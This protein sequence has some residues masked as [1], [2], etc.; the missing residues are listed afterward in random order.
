[1]TSRGAKYWNSGAIPLIAPEILG[2]IITQISDVGVV[3][4]ETGSVL[5]VLV[6]PMND[7]FQALHGLEGQDFRTGLTS[8]SVEKFDERLQSFLEGGETGNVRP[9][10]LNHSY[11]QVSPDFPVRYSFH[12]I[13]PDGAILLLG[14]DLK[15]VAEMQQQLVK[16]QI[17]LE[18]DYEA[19]RESDTRYRVLMEASREA[20]VFV[21]VHD[22]RIVEGNTAAGALLGRRRDDLP[23]AGL[24]ELC[25]PKRKG[26]LIETLRTQALSD[27]PVP[28][29]ALVRHGKEPVSLVPTIFRSAGERML[30][31][32]IEPLSEGKVS[33]DALSNRLIDLY[34]SGPDAIV[35]TD[36]GGTILSA[37]EGFLDLIDTAHDLSVKGRSLTEFLHRGSV[38][39]RVLSEN[40]ARAGRMRMYATKV[41]GDYTRP[42]S[43]EIA[44][45]ALDAGEAQIF[46]YVIRDV[47]RAE[48]VRSAASPVSDEGMR[49]VMELVGSAT[50]KEI[51]SETTNVVEKMC[52]E[53]AV[54][55]TMNNRVA[56]A[57]MLGLSRQSL[58]VKLR[59][60]GL[61]SRDDEA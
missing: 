4:S 54:E 13:G 9:I 30:L 32:R 38:D 36:A 49:S 8:E 2:D 28:V 53:T 46:A 6:N 11:G 19:Q 50:L 17:A 22:G 29:D 45:T 18:R 56:A 10:E 41:M 23:E 24:S 7:S 44:A 43:V 48:T 14:R 37:N 27:R 40:A 51:V 20:Y 39:L 16:A 25:E 59:K 34:Q 42:R 47:S 1:M 52:I 21:S 33:Q 58:Y 60:Y 31:V 3:V 61:L 12:R 5:S 57:E 15:P 26:D 55:L 35:F